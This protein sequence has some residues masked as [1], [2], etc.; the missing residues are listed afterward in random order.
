MLY[1]G[2]FHSLVFHSRTTNSCS[3]C[4]VCCIWRCYQVAFSLSFC[5]NLVSTQKKKKNW[6]CS[7]YL[8]TSCILLLPLQQSEHLSKLLTNLSAQAL[9]LSI[10]VLLQYDCFFV[11]SLL[12]MSEYLGLKTFMLQLIWKKKKKE[13]QFMGQSEK[14]GNCQPHLTR[15]WLS[16]FKPE[17]C[18]EREALKPVLQCLSWR[19]Q[20]EKKRNLQ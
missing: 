14:E 17:E 16:S 3:A 4:D 19:E 2:I 12:R 7:I 1:F 18:C 15:C 6:V 11:F 9:S 13:G 20:K 10:P 8:Y 5:V